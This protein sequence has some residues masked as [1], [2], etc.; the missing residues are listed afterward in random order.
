[1]E[2]PKNKKRE[3]KHAQKESEET[4]DKT[5]STKEEEVKLA[6]KYRMGINFNMYVGDDTGLMKKVKMV[7]N[8]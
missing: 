2:P 1:M 6:L 8:Y 4:K 7:Y 5:E 3:V